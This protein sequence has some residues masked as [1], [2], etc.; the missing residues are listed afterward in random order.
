MSLQRSASFALEH[1][2]LFAFSL[3][4][5]E[6]RVACGAKLLPQRTLVALYQR[7]FFRQR[8]PSA[9]DHLDLGWRIAIQRF[10]GQP[11]GLL[12]QRE[13]ARLRLLARRGQRIAQRR[14]GGVEPRIKLS[15]RL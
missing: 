1:L 9:L 2:R 6:Y 12:N 13:P 15:P 8:L 3:T 5:F 7:Q 11:G 4:R 14:Q 10:S